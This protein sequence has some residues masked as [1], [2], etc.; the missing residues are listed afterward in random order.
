MRDP[1]RVFLFLATVGYSRRVYAAA[2]RLLDNARALVKHH[3]AATR[4]R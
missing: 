3:D 2:L 1:A 4:E